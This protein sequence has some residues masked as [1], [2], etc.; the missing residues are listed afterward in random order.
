MLARAPDEEQRDFNEI[1]FVPPASKPAVV[2]S[3]RVRR[4]TFKK[5]RPLFRKFRRGDGA[6]RVSAAL[7]AVIMRP[8]NRE[9]RRAVERFS[10]VTCPH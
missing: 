5:V 8:E 4:R 9:N 1:H 7:S 10:D 2:T 3:L 6:H